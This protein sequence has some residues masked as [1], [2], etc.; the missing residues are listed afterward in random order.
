MKVHLAF[1]Q[2]SDTDSKQP[3]TLQL[4]TGQALAS[5]RMQKCAASMITMELQHWIQ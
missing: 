3:K 5:V 4:K 1:E 2:H